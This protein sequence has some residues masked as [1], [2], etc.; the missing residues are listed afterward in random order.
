MQLLL[1]THVVVWA[2]FATNQVGRRARAMIDRALSAESLLI[3]AVSLWEVARLV[4]TGRIAIDM[5]PA[6]WRK[7]ILDGGFQEVTRDGNISVRAAELGR[8]SG[9]PI[10]RFIVA[11]ALARGAALVTADASILTW[12][13]PL[14]RYDAAQ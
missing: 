3:S 1:D 4:H 13:G 5:D 8:L 7:N 12:R 6:A 9:D 14:A 10:D 2:A 11:T